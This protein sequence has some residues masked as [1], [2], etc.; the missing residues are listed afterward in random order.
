MYAPTDSPSDVD[1]STMLSLCHL[2]SLS[3]CL[4]SFL[5]VPNRLPLST[6]LFQDQDQNMALSSLQFS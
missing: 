1:E 2:S 5:S 4:L 3:V 6:C